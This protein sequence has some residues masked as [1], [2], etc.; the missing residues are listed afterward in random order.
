MKGMEE[1][2]HHDGFSLLALIDCPSTAIRRT[3][4][5][6]LIILIVDEHAKGAPSSDTPHRTNQ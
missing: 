4:P 2:T 6:V 1:L 5:V 3:W